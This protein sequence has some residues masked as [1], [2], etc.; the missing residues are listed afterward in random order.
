MKITT[1]FQSIVL[2][3]TTLIVFYIWFKV[4]AM[5]LIN[6]YLK[7]IAT[8]LI[9]LSV[10]N[11]VASFFLLLFRKSMRIRK[12][13]LG[14]QFVEGTWVGF[15]IGLQGNVRYTIEHIEQDFETII[16]RG[17]AYNEMQRFHTS[18]I[19]SPANV[20]VVKGEMNYMYE[21]KGIQENMIG[22]GVAF[23]SFGRQDQ[24][25]APRTL[26]G[27]SADLHHAGQRVRS[28]EYKIEDRHNKADRDLLALAVAF[29]NDNVN[30]F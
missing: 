20:D 9:S 25:T 2:S 29:Y 3:V 8:S 27:F 6:P 16:V 23:F 1:R 18:W 13:F 30:T 10:Y 24:Y 4:G 5:I 14:A 15:Y 11:Y 17:T 26:R 22:T 19:S 21:L 28:L 7:I 12:Y